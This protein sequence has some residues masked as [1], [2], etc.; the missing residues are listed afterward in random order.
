M[1]NGATPPMV[2]AVD[3]ANAPIVIVGAGPVGLASA[4]SL[5]CHGIRSIV[6]E[7]RRD[8]SALPRA[9]FVNARSMEIFRQLGVESLVRLASV[10]DEK[11]ANAVWLPALVA[12]DVRRRRIETVGA[13]SGEPRSPAPGVTTSQDRL[14]PIL[15]EGARATGL[16][17]V[18]FGHRVSGVTQR[19]DG[20]SVDYTDEAGAARSAT[21]SYVLAADGASSGVRELLGIPTIGPSGLGHTVNI[22]FRADLDRAVRGR[23]VNLAFI[24]NPRQ[25]GLLLNIDGVTQWTAQALY[26][27]TLG[28]RPEDYTAER[29]RDVIRTQVGDRS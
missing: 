11:T 22:H 1:A 13:P 28:Q 29:C 3:E 19:D 8:V 24:M 2:R 6:L 27:P 5:A 21:A 7:R 17:E 23:G 12:D 4:L 18:R 9:R 16:V 20:V 14:D 25:P 10:P 15:L 26:N